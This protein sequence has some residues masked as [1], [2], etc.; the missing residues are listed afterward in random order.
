MP[1]VHIG[2]GC[3]GHAKDTQWTTKEKV[4]NMLS[5]TWQTCAKGSCAEDGIHAYLTS[6]LS[7]SF[8]QEPKI[9]F[10]AQSHASAQLSRKIIAL[11]QAQKFAHA[12]CTSSSGN[13]IQGAAKSLAWPAFSELLTRV[14]NE[15]SCGLPPASALDFCCA[16]TPPPLWLSCL[17]SSPAS[18]SDGASCSPL[19]TSVAGDGAAGFKLAAATLVVQLKMAGGRRLA[20]A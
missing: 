17:L 15:N 10:I 20:S 1:H 19:A 14:A 4:K 16:D 6:T 12:S 5:T 3:K 18:S 11:L 13:T 2:T 9:N 7:T 8:T